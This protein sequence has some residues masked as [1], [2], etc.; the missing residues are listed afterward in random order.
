MAAIVFHSVTAKV[1]GHFSLIEKS[2]LRL[3]RARAHNAGHAA[4]R[5]VNT[6]NADAARRHS[7]IEKTRLHAEAR[8]IGQQPMANGSSK[9]SSIS[10]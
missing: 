7:Q 9:D 1:S 2:F 3:E 10:R 6:E 5:P 4:I 8:R